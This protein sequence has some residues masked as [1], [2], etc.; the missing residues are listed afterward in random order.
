MKIRTKEFRNAARTILY[1]IDSKDKNLFSD[2]LELKTDGTYLYLSTTNRAYYVT[3]KFDLGYEEAFRATVN[4]QLFL[5]L[6]SKVTTDEITITQDDRALKI[7]ANGEY[8]VPMIYQTDTL[9]ELPKIEI[10][11][12]TN[13]MKVNSNIL[14]SINLYNSKELVRGIAVKPVQNYYYVD[15]KGAITFTSGACVN[16]FTLPQ[17][18]KI[19]LDNKVVKLFR[20]FNE[21]EE[22]TMTIGQD[23]L[24][25]TIIQSK[26]KFSTP[27]VDITAILPD[28]GLISSV[29]VDAIRGMA[30]NTYNYSV[31]ID[32]DI[33]LGA[34]NRLLLFNETNTYGHFEFTHDALTV[35]DYS[36]DN[37]EVVPLVNDVPGLDYK[38][39]TDLANF[40]LILEG[41]EDQY[42]TISFGDGKA[43][44]V[45]KNAI[46]NIIPE[47]KA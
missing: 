8:K 14:S 34:L 17:P 40:K 23:A 7:I 15:D 42:V 10:A 9:V 18:V 5:N 6:I 30:T 36:E 47:I 41:S 12:P 3:V 26:V 46:S 16:T 21:D 43:I 29:P 37:K 20:L 28:T 19:L 25:D 32:K 2:T 39:I 11:N 1:A 44:V 13:T 45:V 27:R 4:A 35:L 22:V 33:L 24:S 38:L 31:V